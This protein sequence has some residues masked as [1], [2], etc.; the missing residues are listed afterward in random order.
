MDYINKN[1]S[2]ITLIYTDGFVSPLLTDFVFAVPGFHIFF[3]YN[4]LLIASS[5]TAEYYPIIES[6]LLGI[7][8]LL[9]IVQLFAATRVDSLI[10]KL[11]DQLGSLN[12]NNNTPVM[13]CG[14]ITP[15]NNIIIN[16]KKYNIRILQNI[17]KHG[18]PR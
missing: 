12:I 8:L 6:L 2:E 15:Q 9:R 16:K 11:G 14:F 3:A 10:G 17:Y 13:G 7:L 4:L 18:R 1:F 5:F